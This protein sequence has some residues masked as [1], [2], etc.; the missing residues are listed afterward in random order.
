[1]L[2]HFKVH[3]ELELP[4]LLTKHAQNA[5]ALVGITDPHS[6]DPPPALQ[7]ISEKH[8]T[9]VE[10][11]GVRLGAANAFVNALAPVSSVMIVVGM[12]ILFAE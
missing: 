11:V 10:E 8:A 6:P 12:S 2:P 9:E 1:M 7:D 5:P 4:L 3:C